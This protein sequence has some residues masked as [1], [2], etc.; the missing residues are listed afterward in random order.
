MSYD[1]AVFD[2]GAA[3]KD[4]QEFLEWDKAAQAESSYD[5]E[6]C[7]PRL[8]AWFMEMIRVFPAMNGPFA[9]EELPQDEASMTDYSIGRSVICANFAWSK[10]EL[11]YDLTFQ[12]AKKH[13]LGVFNVSSPQGEVWL[14]D[15]RGGF[16][17]AHSQ[18][19][20]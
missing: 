5:S 1:L 18:A 8:R 4:R 10:A 19:G 14:P 11:A 3:P 16:G 15:G 17:I 6:I 12:L 13:E 20:G 7:A 2:P 9:P